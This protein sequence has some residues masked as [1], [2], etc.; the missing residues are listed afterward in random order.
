MPRVGTK[1]RV[2]KTSSS[3][4]PHEAKVVSKCWYILG[5]HDHKAPLVKVVRVVCKHKEAQNL[6]KEQ[7]FSKQQV[8]RISSRG[9]LLLQ[10]TEKSPQRKRK[11]K[12]KKH[13]VILNIL[14]LSFIYCACNISTTSPGAPTLVCDILQPRASSFVCFVS[15]FVG[16]I[17]SSIQCEG[18]SSS[19]RPPALSA[20]LI[21]SVIVLAK[22]KPCIDVKL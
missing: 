3:E 11:R 22:P 15:F 12:K 14:H 2:Q 6:T 10:S 5:T 18:S 17:R 21:F 4:A 1:A 9:F 19:S 8:R 13:N 20:S 7:Y 16:Y